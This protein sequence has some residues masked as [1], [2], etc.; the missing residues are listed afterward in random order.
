MHE[1]YYTDV[2]DLALLKLAEDLVWNDY[3]R[4]VCLPTSDVAGGTMCWITGWGDTA[5]T[6]GKVT[7]WRHQM[8]IFSALLAFL[9]G[10]NRSPVNSSL[11]MASNWQANVFVYF[12]W[13]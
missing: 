8:E 5:G 1:G 7:W 4:P 6:L 9:R 10:I 13:M 3:V 11:K 2:Q 12:S